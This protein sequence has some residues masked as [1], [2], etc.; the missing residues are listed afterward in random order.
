MDDSLL[1]QRCWTCLSLALTIILLLCLAS[2]RARAAEEE[3]PETAP[4]LTPVTP[5]P[6][7]LDLATCRRIA[8]EKQPVLP[9]YRASLAAAEAKAQAI[10]GLF[11]PGLLAHDLQIRRHQAALGVASAEGQLHQAEWETVYAVTRTYWAVVYAREQAA[12]ARRVLTALDELKKSLPNKGE[13]PPKEEKTLDLASRTLIESY[14]GVARGRQAEALGGIERARGALREAMG[15]EQDE[16]VDVVAQEF[17]QIELVLCG[18]QA[19]ELALRRRGDLRQATLAAEVVDWEVKAQESQHG[20]IGRTFATAADIHAQPVPQGFRDGEYHPAAVGVEM[21]VDLP[22]TRAHRVEQAQALSDRAHAAALKAR[23]L[24]ELEVED[25]YQ[26]WE[27]A[28]TRGKQLQEAVGAAKEHYEA[29][30]A[31][32]KDGTK[33]VEDVVEAGRLGSEIR[34]ELNET[35]FRAQLIL[36]ALERA[37]AGGV[38]PY[39][40]LAPPQ[41]P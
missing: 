35:L 25:L 3:Q 15:L 36:A 18:K 11:V 10:D 16:C 5:A 34:A 7:V 19:R 14:L 22:G 32:Y 38:C 20:M 33:K 21:P 27:A 26:K 39:P 24:V 9:A 28:S 8:L 6:Q 29:I 37:T 4:A 17:P 41:H 12:L 2:E 31:L 23:N 40:H 13:K 30:R 1:V